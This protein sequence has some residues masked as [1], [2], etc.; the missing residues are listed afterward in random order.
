VG[1]KNEIIKFAQSKVFKLK[2][3]S[4][5]KITTMTTVGYGDV[6]PRTIQGKK[7]LEFN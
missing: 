7:N 5:K 2:R 4:L 6:I 1:G 3:F